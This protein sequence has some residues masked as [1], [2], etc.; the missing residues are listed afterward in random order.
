MEEARQAYRDK[1]KRSA[2]KEFE[3]D[4]AVPGD[5]P[6][7]PRHDADA[8]ASPAD[9]PA[10]AQPAI[11]SDS[12]A[13]GDSDIPTDL[14]PRAL[15]AAARSRAHDARNVA[16]TDTTPV[17]VVSDTSSDAS[18]SPNQRR[19]QRLARRIERREQQAQSSAAYLLARLTLME[20]IGALGG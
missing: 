8:A 1:C 2:R 12:I 3:P 16:V 20:E 18:V 5:T 11:S 6:M 15:R 7:P 9:A 19:A 14:D 10:S 13:S 4:T 17:P